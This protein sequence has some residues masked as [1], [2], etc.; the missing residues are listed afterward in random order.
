MLSAGSGDTRREMEV[1]A[2]DYTSLAGEIKPRFMQN[3]E[4][5]LCFRDV[6]VVA[7]NYWVKW[8][9]NAVGNMERGV[10]KTKEKDG[11]REGEDGELGGLHFGF[12][13]DICRGL[14]GVVAVCGRRIVLEDGWNVAGKGGAVDDAYFLEEVGEAQEGDVK[15][16]EGDE[17][18]FEGAGRLF[19]VELVKA[20]D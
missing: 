14:R 5:V 3:G 17:T 7:D 19:E 16:V 6:G 13:R 4:D 20:D 8:A 10:E 15:R 18:N 1:G 11:L 2:G 9:E 12:A